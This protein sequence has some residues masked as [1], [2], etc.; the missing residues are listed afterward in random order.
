MKGEE[1]TPGENEAEREGE[2]KL[3]FIRPHDAYKYEMCVELKEE[4][5]FPS[6]WGFIH[7]LS[8]TPS[9]TLF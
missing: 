6:A 8:S 1:T 2:L 5:L 9:C 4:Q 3:K 7:V